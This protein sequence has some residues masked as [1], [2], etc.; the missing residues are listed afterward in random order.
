MND[1]WQGSREKNIIRLDT[2]QGI[3][4]LKGVKEETILSDTK[5][6][7]KDFTFDVDLKK[8][9][10]VIEQDTENN[11]TTVKTVISK[12]EKLA[13]NGQ[14]CRT[15]GDIKMTI[16]NDGEEQQFEN[17]TFNK[18]PYRG[19]EIINKTI[20]DNIVETG[21]TEA[22]GYNKFNIEKNEKVE[23]NFPLHYNANGIFKIPV[24]NINL[25]KIIKIQDTEYKIDNQSAIL[26]KENKSTIY[27]T[28]FKYITIDVANNNGERRYFNI[29]GNCASDVV[30][31]LKC[32]SAT[33]MQIQYKDNPKIVIHEPEAKNTPNFFTNLF[34]CCCGKTNNN[35]ESELNIE[36][37]N[38][39]KDIQD[40]VE[41]QFTM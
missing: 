38:R 17:F 16:I 1:Q 11:T 27:K 12:P 24:K 41:K 7:Y 29:A 2:G 5:C 3:K 23:Y 33:E 25:P 30:K 21:I 4:S 31:E 14:S 32:N 26:F 39:F 37:L 9:N 35:K 20:F 34:C 8:V 28:P 22:F 36:I 19:D 13:F 40:I 18:Q 10:S 15:Q 6:K